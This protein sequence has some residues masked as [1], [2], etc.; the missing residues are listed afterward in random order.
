VH[1]KDDFTPLDPEILEESMRKARSVI[2]EDT[3]VFIY[4]N[5][6][7]I[8]FWVL[9]PD[10]NQL[11]K[12]IDG[13]LDPISLVKFLWHK[14]N[15]RMTRLRAVVGGVKHSHQN[16]GIEAAIFYHLFTVFMKK[17]WYKEVELSW[18]GDYNQRMMASN[19]A[20]GGIKMKTHIT[21]RYLMNKNIQFMRFKDEMAEKQKIK[22]NKEAEL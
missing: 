22:T 19:E 21:Y 11:L 10:L 17:P 4:Q 2:D 3:V 18:V 12:Y 13:K 9:L 14:R 6:K 8:G 7:P 5:D 15:H 16:Q 20:L 1:F